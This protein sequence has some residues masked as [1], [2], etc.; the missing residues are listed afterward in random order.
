[1]QPAE[2]LAPRGRAGASLASRRPPSSAR[3]PPLGAGRGLRPAAPPVRVATSTNE[4]GAE[5]VWTARSGWPVRALGCMCPPGSH[6][7]RK[8]RM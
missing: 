5:P 6:P 2:D 3:R 7:P 1:M 4:P 8:L